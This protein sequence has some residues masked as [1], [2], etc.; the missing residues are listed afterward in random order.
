[1]LHHTGTES[2]LWMRFIWGG[3]LLEKQ[4]KKKKKELEGNN[5]LIH[6]YNHG[7]TFKCILPGSVCVR[8]CPPLRSPT[9]S[10]L[11]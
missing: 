1:M 2:P 4:P 8:V 11:L 6:A 7:F 5:Y 10:R 3:G 9:H